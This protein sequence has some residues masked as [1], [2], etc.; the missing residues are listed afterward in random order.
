LSSDDEERGS[1]MP[2]SGML[3]FR[4]I[5]PAK[6][7][8]TGPGKSNF[9]PEDGR[10]L[11]TRREAITAKGAHEAYIA[12]GGLSIGTWGVSVAEVHDA[13]LE[14]FDDEH[15]E[16]NPPY[17]AT[18]WFPE[19][20]TRGQQERY[21]RQLHGSGSRVHG[22]GFRETRLLRDTTPAT[23]TSHRLHAE[24]ET[25]LSCKLSGHDRARPPNDTGQPVNVDPGADQAVRKYR[26]CHRG[27]GT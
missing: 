10:R 26:Y 24:R 15:I 23:P 7:K 6:M 17:H 12:E 9:I 2:R 22:S 1:S 14:P 27:P 4:Q 19:N 13:G 8:S 25:V 21:A 11:S 16:D 18:I 5:N 3:L 20:Q